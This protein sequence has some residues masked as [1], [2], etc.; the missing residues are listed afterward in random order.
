MQ[1]G[2]AIMNSM[3]KFPHHPQMIKAIL[4][5][6]WKSFFDYDITYS[7]FGALEVAL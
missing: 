6:V 5:V 3:V 4:V 2:N 1:H 7:L